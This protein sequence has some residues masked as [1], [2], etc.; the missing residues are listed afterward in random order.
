MREIIWTSLSCKMHLYGDILL[1]VPVRRVARGGGA[2]GA[3]APPPP[4]KC[5]KKKKKKGEREKKGGKNCVYACE[6]PAFHLNSCYTRKIWAYAPNCTINNITENAKKLSPSHTPPP[7]PRSLRS[8]G[9][10]RFAPS[11]V[12]FTAPLLKFNPSYATGTCQSNTIAHKAV[13]IPSLY[14]YYYRYT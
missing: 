3:V 1:E 14:I 2:V 10:G 8:L 4:P 7:P 9:L 12:I 6:A 11:H 13:I 5:K